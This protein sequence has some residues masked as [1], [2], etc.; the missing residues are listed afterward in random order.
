MS[1][2]RLNPVRDHA[3]NLVPHPDYAPLD[4]DEEAEEL[5]ERQRIFQKIKENRKPH[6]PIG[7]DEVLRMIPKR[8]YVR[9]KLKGEPK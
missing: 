3:W 5:A 1:N 2:R 7:E 8:R 9:R 4:F 6:V